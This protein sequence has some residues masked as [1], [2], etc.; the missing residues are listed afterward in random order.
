MI[1]PIHFF[2]LK[3]FVAIRKS[4]NVVAQRE[5]IIFCLITM[6]SFSYASMNVLSFENGS[7]NQSIPN[8]QLQNSDRDILGFNLYYYFSAAD[9]KN[10]LMDSY[11]L[12]GGYSTNEWIFKYRLLCCKMD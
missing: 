12:A 5:K 4:L 8:I 3:L 6:L 11:F 7:Q 2:N 10:V 9:S 1:T